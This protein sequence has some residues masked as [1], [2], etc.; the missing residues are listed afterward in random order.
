[1]FFFPLPFAGFEPSGLCLTVECST[2][3]LPGTTN[4]DWNMD[5][6]KLYSFKTWMFHSLLV[7]PHSEM[8]DHLTPNHKFGGSNSANSGGKYLW[9][10]AFKSL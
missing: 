10:Y 8:V 2:I 3:A 1:M 9:F 7:V 4:K 5:V 6:S